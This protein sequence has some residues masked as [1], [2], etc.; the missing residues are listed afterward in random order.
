MVED[1]IVYP[2][3]N[4][5]NISHLINKNLFILKEALGTKFFRIIPVICT[6]KENPFAK[7]IYVEMLMYITTI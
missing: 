7:S 2:S 1:A 4:P 6:I 3:T 5:L